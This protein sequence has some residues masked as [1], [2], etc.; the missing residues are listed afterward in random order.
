MK[1]KL[2]DTE[3]FG[4]ETAGYERHLSPHK[5]KALATLERKATD[6]CRDANLFRDPADWPTIK[7]ADPLRDIF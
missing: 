5:R 6:Y 3:M 1:R 7:T 4:D 2:S